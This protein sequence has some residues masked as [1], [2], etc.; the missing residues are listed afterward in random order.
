MYL[1][2]MSIENLDVLPS[3]VNLSAAEIELIGVDNKEYII[4]N[5]VE[6]VKRQI[7]IILS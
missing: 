1:Q 6:K 4:K 5:E 3:N 7:M 2:R